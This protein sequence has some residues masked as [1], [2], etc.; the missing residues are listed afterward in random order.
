MKVPCGVVRDLLPLYAEDLVGEESRAL[1]EEHLADCPDCRKTLEDMKQPKPA[2]EPD[3]AEALRAVKRDIRRRRLT[4]V[5]L[6]A[7]LVFLPLF[8]LLARA[9][10]KVAVPWEKDLF[11]VESEED[12]ALVFSFDGRIS[13]VEGDLCTDPDSGET[14]LLLQGWSS[15][16]N[17]WTEDARERGTY[18]FRPV[19]DRVIYG[20]GFRDM[21]QK[22]LYGKPANGGVHILPRLALGYYLLLALAAA[23]VLGLLWLIFRKKK[24]AAVLKALFFA[25]LSYPVGHLLVKGTQT[26]SFFLLRDLA[27]IL[28]AAAAVWGLL[29][30]LWTVLFA[31]EKET[32]RRRLKGL[33]IG[34]LA[35][36]L[37]MFAFFVFVPGSYGPTWEVRA[38]LLVDGQP[39]GEKNITI[40]RLGSDYF[41]ELPLKTVIEALGGEFTWEENDGARI[42]AEGKVFVLD[43]DRLRDSAGN[44]LCRDDR[45]QFHGEEGEYPH[46]LYLEHE[47]VQSVL[48]ML[49]FESA[50]ITIDPRTRTVSVTQ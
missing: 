40:Y 1:V 2:P 30:L 48:R 15:A 46:E 6:A 26:M 5:L 33:M 20:Y 12:G 47:T 34:I 42:E 14:T 29:M 44:T 37:L 50:E 36:V 11:R 45:L 38:Q 10:D 16:W 43:G 3:G 25:A 13:A 18:T 7:L 17:D 8:A 9:T 31:V 32:R 24:A 49:G 19:P 28:I 39:V 35:I 23:A 22:F 27:F 4:A 41:S 21:G